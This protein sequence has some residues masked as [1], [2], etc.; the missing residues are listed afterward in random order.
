MPSSRRS[1]LSQR[2]LDL[3]GTEWMDV[4]EFMERAIPLVPPGRAMREWSAG[5]DRLVADRRKRQEE[6]KKLLPRKRTPSESEKIRQGARGI[7]NGFLG[8]ARDRHLV[9]IEVLGSRHERR[10]R[11]SDE[12][13][14]AHHCCLHG[15]TCRGSAHDEPTPPEPEEDPLA[16]LIARVVE[17]RRKREEEARRQREARRHPFP[18]V[19]EVIPGEIDRLLREC[20]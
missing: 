15:G 2:L 4:E 14:Y 20:G 3:I 19:R 9:E 13:R 1:A 11:L 8:D 16:D 7:V 10:I 17:S 18:G 6:G 5:E 12:R